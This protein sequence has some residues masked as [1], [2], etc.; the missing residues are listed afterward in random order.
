MR[1]R[2]RLEQAIESVRAMEAEVE[3]ATTLIEAG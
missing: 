3:D 1:E 2:T